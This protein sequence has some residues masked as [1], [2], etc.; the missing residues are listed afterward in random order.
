M[1]D[2]VTWR[3]VVCMWEWE[4][5][6]RV[7]EITCGNRVISNLSCCHNAPHSFD[8]TFMLSTSVS[9][10]SPPHLSPYPLSIHRHHHPSSNRNIHSLVKSYRHSNHHG[11]WLAYYSLPF[12]SASF[13]QQHL[14]LHQDASSRQAFRTMQLLWGPW[15]GQGRQG[16]HW[17]IPRSER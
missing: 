1:S 3:R 2:V 12:T 7:S 16:R 13:C 15:A 6:W 4:K 5:L 17:G 14:H 9:S 10:L 11:S 8:L